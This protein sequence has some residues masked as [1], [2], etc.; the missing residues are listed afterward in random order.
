MREEEEPEVP[1][2]APG[3][4]DVLGGLHRLG[5]VIPDE[6]TPV[7]AD[8]PLRGPRFQNC[9]LLCGLA[10]GQCL[11]SSEIELVLEN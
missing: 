3:A 2:P 9:E 4:Q 7:T 6:V 8:R 1:R 5:R 10:K 11:L